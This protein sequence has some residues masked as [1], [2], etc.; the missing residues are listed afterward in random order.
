[1][2][3]HNAGEPAEQ[4]DDEEPQASSAPVVI[5]STEDGMSDM[6]R[7]AEP[8]T[9]LLE[10]HS[11]SAPTSGWRNFA[12]LSLSALSGDTIWQQVRDRNR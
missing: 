2:S 3:Q 12:S 7:H 6:E 4:E 8:D 10:E 1:M 5:S 9:R 11:T